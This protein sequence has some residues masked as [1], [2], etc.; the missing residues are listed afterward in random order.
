MLVHKLMY[1][2]ART[3][4]ARG[5][6]ICHLMDSFSGYVLVIAGIFICL[7]KFGVNMTALSLTGGVAGV[8]FGIGCQNIVADILAGIIMA[9]D[10][11]VHVGDLVSYNGQFGVVFSIGVRTTILK[12]FG[13][14]TVIRNNDFK[15]F[16]RRPAEEQ[17]RVIAS[18]KIDQHES[19][20]RINEILDRELPVVHDN[21][22]A[23]VGEE[24]SG[25]TFRGVDSIDESGMLLSF[26][27]LCKGM[28][29][30]LVPRA[31]NVELKLMCERNNIKLSSYQVV[32]NDPQKDKDQK[33]A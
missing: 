25:P 7:Y 4:G 21:L 27:I 12:W 33:K 23:A 16:I 2:I 28:L 22:C 8:V 29:V 3:A 32:L 17:A 20:Q 14:I 1:L 15:N 19:L 30:G 5:E 18:L 26:S 11:S 10:G 6:T 13:D 31:L 24:I 9:F